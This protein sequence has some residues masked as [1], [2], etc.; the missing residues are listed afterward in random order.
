VE[1]QAEL[2]GPEAL[3]TEPT[4]EAGVLEIANLLL[5]LPRWTYQS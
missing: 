5:G 4:R 2:I 3:T 1:Q